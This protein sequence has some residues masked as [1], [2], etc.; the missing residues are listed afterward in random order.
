MKA[1]EA[2]TDETITQV[3][4]EM[5]KLEAVKAVT[6]QKV[7]ELESV[8]AVTEAKVI[9]LMAG[10]ASVQ[11]EVRRL[12]GLIGLGIGAGTTGGGKGQGVWADRDQKGHKESLINTKDMVPDRLEDRGGWRKWKVDVIDFCEE[13]F[14]GM[15]D[16][17]GK[18]L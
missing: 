14:A 9:E 1:T 8:K 10:I 5:A 12:E 7:S 11:A 18:A 16:A 3:R 6:E 17:L 15:K 4:E 13:K 2:K